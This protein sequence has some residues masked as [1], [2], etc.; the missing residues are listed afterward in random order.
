MGDQTTEIDRGIQSN[1][2][3]W[4]FRR[5]STP[6][7]T[8]YHRPSW[9]QKCCVLG[10]G[11]TVSGGANRGLHQLQ[12]YSAVKGRQFCHTLVRSKNTSQPK[13]CSVSPGAHPVRSKSVLEDFQQRLMSMVPGKAELTNLEVQQSL[14]LY[15]LHRRSLREFC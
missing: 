2:A 10:Y 13:I 8:F 11:W 9:G 12:E 15:L 14:G 7:A 3:T 1:Q 4:F 5:L 6:L